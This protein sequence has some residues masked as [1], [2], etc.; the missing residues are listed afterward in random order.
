MI[1]M[2]E[3]L[4]VN[5]TPQETRVAVIEN[6]SLQEVQVERTSHRGYVGNIYKGRVVRV[7]PG[8]QAVF[9]DIG[10]QRTGF[11]HAADMVAQRADR[12]P[13]T[14]S[15]QGMLSS[16]LDIM[17]LAHEG[18]E[19]VVQVT[20][21]PIGSKGTR[22]TTQLSLPSRH[23]VLLPDS[24]HLGVSQRIQ[25]PT[26]RDRL[27]Q[28]LNDALQRNPVA[29]GFIVRTVAESLDVTNLTADLTFLE[30]SWQRIQ[31]RIPEAK[32]GD[33]I[34]GDL[35]LTLRMVRDLASDTV[36][37]VRVDSR[38]SF[39][40]IR[41]FAD[42]LIPEVTPRIEHY[43]GERPI[44]DLYSIE[45][46]IQRALSRTVHLKSGGVLIVDQTEAMTTID[47][48]TGAYVG[49]RNLEDTIF[50]TNLEA[51]QSIARQL[52]LR[53]IG[54]IV[55]VDFIDMADEEHRRQVMRALER[56]L[57]RDRTPCSITQMSLLG[58]VEITRKRTRESLE[59][60]MTEPCRVC[61]GRG[62][63]K[64]PQTVCYEIFREVVRQSRAFDAKAHMILAA[65]GVIDML[66][67][68]EAN[69]LADL[70]AFIGRPVQL[71]VE[72][73]YSQEIYDVVLM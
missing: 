69:A 6:G 2:T 67:A 5:V 32:P 9:V 20:K 51:V 16:G 38:E 59:R 15:A 1:K 43:S 60:M 29:G 14:E 58:L 47:V 45:E 72:P 52:R 73:A 66:I 13:G 17:S 49:R 12:S 41:C 40:S 8:M 62:I 57:S 35:P 21:D 23:L 26:E 56:S 34:H 63:Q 33:L 71:Q 19:L 7:L 24:D 10:L 31:A 11:L 25:D 42:E 64:T 30:R 70:Q 27:R 48:N 68:E 55:I 53:N 46:E 37:R 22:L 39:D 3:E 28:A 54:G 44:F 50:R 18:Q 65:Q 36:E 4:L 61:D